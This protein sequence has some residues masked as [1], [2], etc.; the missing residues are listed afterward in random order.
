[1][2]WCVENV[3]RGRL[4]EEEA[5]WEGGREA[6]EDGGSVGGEGGEQLRTDEEEEEEDEEEEQEDFVCVELVLVLAGRVLREIWRE[7]GVKKYPS[8]SPE[9]LVLCARE[10][11]QE[12]LS[13]TCIQG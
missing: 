8:H 7:G 1:M 9:Q 11:K 2:V 10:T 6:R 3:A 13:P 4:M 5:K 12:L